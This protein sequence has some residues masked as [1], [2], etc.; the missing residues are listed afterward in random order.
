[1]NDWQKIHSTDKLHQADIIMHLL[2]EKG[3]NP[4]LINKKDTNY[5]IGLYEIYVIRTFVLDSIKAISEET[6]FNK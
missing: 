1:M 4:V 3:F 2:E 6:D 5:H